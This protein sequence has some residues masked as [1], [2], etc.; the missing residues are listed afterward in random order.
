M[1]T[2]SNTVRECQIDGVRYISLLDVLKIECVSGNPTRD[3]K[4]LLRGSAPKFKN[5]IR[6]YVFV[7]SDGKNKRPTPVIPLDILEEWRTSMPAAFRVRANI[8][9]IT[10]WVYLLH[11]KEVPDLYKIGTT[12]DLEQRVSGIEKVTPFNVIV[13][14][15]IYSAK[16]LRLEKMLHHKF[17]K[18]RVKYE[19]FHL[20]PP[21][22]AFIKKAQG[23]LLS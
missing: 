11:F 4:R 21:D 6:E 1:E 17:R 15:K 9:D 18:Q 19:W 12:T 16:A 3:L 20:F 14:W 2:T 13:D 8:A 10:G 22:I 5:P 23:L 7:G